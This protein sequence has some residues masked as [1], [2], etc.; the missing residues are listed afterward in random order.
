MFSCWPFAASYGDVG[1][2]LRSWWIGVLT[3]E[4]VIGSS[5]SPSPMEPRIQEHL[6]TSRSPSDSI[7]QGLHTSG[8]SGNAN[9]DPDPVTPHLPLMG[10][11]D[12]SLP[13]AMFA[14]RSLL[15][16]R[17]WRHSQMLAEHFWTR[18][19]RDYLPNLSYLPKQGANGKKM[20]RIL[21][22]ER[23]F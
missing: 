4:L 18:F 14:N 12:A 16:R 21:K 5:K 7:V 13:Q 8:E 11:R 23:W 10:R 1:S 19:I 9:A 17:K 6:T 20:S 3:S 22:S 2:P 15:G